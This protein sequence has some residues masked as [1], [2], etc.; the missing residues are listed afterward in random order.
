MACTLPNTQFRYVYHL[1]PLLILLDAAALV[2]LARSLASLARGPGVS[3]FES[4]YGRAVGT[5][6]LAVLVAVGGGM[7]VEL[8]EMDRFRVEGI[9][10]N[11]F[12][13][14]D[15][16]GPSRYVKDHLRAGDV[17]LAP[18]LYQVYHL[19][20]ASEPATRPPGYTLVT[21]P[22]F[23]PAT[24]TDHDGVLVDRRDGAPVIVSQD[25]LEDLFARHPRIWYIVQPGQH[26]VLNTPTTSAF[27]REHMEVVYEDWE[28]LVLFRGDTHR[29]VYLRLND[30]KSL[31]DALANFLP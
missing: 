30:E 20:D 23:L 9:S 1:M 12:K 14:P 22:F 10:P 6:V 5:F 27:L 18:H 21:G 28:T 15:L 3:P 8:R 17:V 13:Y 31:N 4:A 19:M 24:L 16:G 25:Q 7:T 11:L 2:A 26:N 29:P